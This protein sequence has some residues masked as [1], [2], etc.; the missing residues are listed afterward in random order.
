MNLPSRFEVIGTPQYGGFG[1]VTTCKDKQLNRTVVI[2]Q[3]TNPL[4]LSRI[5]DEVV[6]LQEAK[7]KH[8]VEIY[9]VLVNSTGSEICIVEEYLSGHDLTDFDFAS[10]SP[11]ELYKILFQISAGL[12]DIH[13]R[14]VVHRDIKPENMK[15][16]S[17]GYV[18]I[19]DFGLAKTA[20]LPATTNS[21]TGTPGFMAPELFASPLIDKPVDIYAFGALA[22]KIITKSEPP[23]ASPWPLPP[24]ALAVADGIENYGLTNPRL[25]PLINRCLQLSPT[26]RP[27]AAELAR[28]FERELLRGQHR[29]TLVSGNNI[30]T[31]DQIGK[32]VVAKHLGNSI[33]VTYDGLDFIVTAVTGAA[34]V[35]NKPA[36]V[37]MI[38]PGSAV[39]TLGASGPRRF[40]PF[41][42]SHPE[43]KI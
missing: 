36:S 41:D 13:A 38:L 23:C 26:A 34:F 28:A 1:H 21:L 2:K 3:I 40:V 37:G 43:V 11:D 8:V 20:S 29:A 17:E 31:L 9:D 33:Q 10:A 39:I 5:V 35:N 25:A 15:F 14:G 30:F 42:V 19:F 7:S 32:P 6:A 22:F 27:T 12:S 4:H 24:T 18:R 16:D